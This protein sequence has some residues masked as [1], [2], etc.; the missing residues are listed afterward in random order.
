MESHYTEQ[1]Y[2]YHNGIDEQQPDLWSNTDPPFQIA[3][4]TADRRKRY[5]VFAICPRSYGAAN[6]H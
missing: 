3:T 4:G 5:P 1:L 2:R 6:N